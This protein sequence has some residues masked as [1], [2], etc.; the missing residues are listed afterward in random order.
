MPKEQKWKNPLRTWQVTMKDNSVHS[1][2]A[3]YM[4]D[5]AS[6]QDGQ[7][8]GQ[9]LVFRR[10]MKGDDHFTV[11]AAFNRDMWSHYKEIV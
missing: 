4:F 2:D 6:Q 9:G 8:G 11:V 5:N 3:H 10:C 1:I 7:P